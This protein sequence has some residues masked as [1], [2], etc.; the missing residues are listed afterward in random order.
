[1]LQVP[2]FDPLLKTSSEVDQNQTPVSKKHAGGWF[3]LAQSSR[4]GGCECEKYIPACA[5]SVRDWTRTGQ[6][7]EV[8]I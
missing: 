7:P 2:V 4:D 8:R 1:M 5:H 6:L 3:T